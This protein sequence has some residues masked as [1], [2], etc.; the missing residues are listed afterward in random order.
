VRSPM[1]AEYS[2]GPAA[3]HLRECVTADA[4]AAVE[5]A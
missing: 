4:P 2:S 3:T 5:H 1:V